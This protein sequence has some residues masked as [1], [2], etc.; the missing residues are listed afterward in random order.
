[1][2]I[3]VSKLIFKTSAKRKGLT[4]NSKYYYQTKTED[5]FLSEIEYFYT[6]KEDSRNHFSFLHYGD[7]GY[8]N[9]IQ[10]D[11]A[12][13]MKAEITDFGIVAGDID[14]NKGNNYD[15]GGKPPSAF[16]L[17][18]LEVCSRDV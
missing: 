4:P 8:N 12:K 2:A 17:N 16:W 10:N 9:T 18:G 1:M 6:A 7:C 11:I 5:V 13:L 14:Q 3:T 15:T